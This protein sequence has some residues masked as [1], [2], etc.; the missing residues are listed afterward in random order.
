VLAWYDID[1]RMAA[2]RPI[3]LSD[4]PGA[5]PAIVGHLVDALRHDGKAIAGAS[6]L[7][8]AIGALALLFIPS[9]YEAS[10]FLQVDGRDAEAIHAEFDAGSALNDRVLSSAASE[11]GLAGGPAAVELLRGQVELKSRRLERSLEFV[12]R[13][14][15]AD[16]AARVANALAEAY[17]VW[18]LDLAA[19]E[20]EKATAEMAA[21]LADLSNRVAEAERLAQGGVDE[22]ATQEA[23]RRLASAELASGRSLVEL[24]RQ[25][26]EELRKA[27]RDRALGI[28]LLAD[29]EAPTLPVWPPVL[30]FLASAGLL[31]AVLGLWRV[32]SR[33]ARQ[34]RVYSPDDL[35]G[36][37]GTPCLAVLPAVE[38]GFFRDA[39]PAA[40][41]IREPSSSFG[42]AVRS[43]VAGLQLVDG[44]TPPKIVWVTGPRGGIG[45][46]SLSASIAR[47]A[48]ASGRNQ[49]V[50]LILSRGGFV[51]S[52]RA[53]VE[54]YVAGRADIEALFGRDPA[55]G[56]VVLRSR[57]IERMSRLPGFRELLAELSERFDL[58]VVEA[59][60][61]TT[62]ADAR[63]AAEIADLALVV[64]DWAATSRR[65]AIDSLRLLGATGMRLGS[66]LAQ[67]DLGRVLASSVGTTSGV[68]L[69]RHFGD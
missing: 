9:V 64:V 53:S 15:D 54:D 50:A 17:R 6:I 31:G 30:G 43:L 20:A 19:D 29:A 51:G 66:V 3:E 18:R 23:Q 61:M 45:L 65:Y 58:I 62:T 69:R 49:K 24:F 42:K 56:L 40:T 44:S 16:T 59:P 38:G 4:R 22:E 8:A 63:I 33:R 52:G 12:G 21:R 14:S 25:R 35:E 55:S 48:A 2:A 60:T 7:S 34:D 13:S 68:A 41:A 36:T 32:V 26:L 67:A 37:T 27:E 5:G 47:V 28:R 57:A 39:D 10:A 11:L 1:E 46:D